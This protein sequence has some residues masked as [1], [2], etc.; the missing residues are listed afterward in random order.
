MLIITTVKGKVVKIHPPYDLETDYD[1]TKV[2]V[3]YGHTKMML[4]WRNVV[5]LE[6]TYDDPRDKHII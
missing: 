6:E 3:K 2:I 5:S 1:N 4:P